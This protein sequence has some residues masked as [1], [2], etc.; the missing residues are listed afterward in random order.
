[1]HNRNNTNQGKKDPSPTNSN[2]Q[3]D[4]MN[5][6]DLTTDNLLDMSNAS[7]AFIGLQRKVGIISGISLIVGTMIGS[8]IFASPRYVMVFSGSVGM[9]LIVW[10]LCGVLAMAG[11]FCYA[12]L[13]TMIPLS[14]AEYIYLY[15]GLG[16][17]PAFLYAWTSTI[18]LKPS[19]VA[20]ICLAFG[21]YV[22]EP[23]FPGC[24]EREDLI[25]V[26]KLM[27]A[28]AIVVLTIIGNQMS[29]TGLLAA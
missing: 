6:S 23:F 19:Q 24:S 11:A 20:I 4:F 2:E 28:L 10:S 22:I 13:G 14:G 8:G 21:A 9:T 29:S 18:I 26:V 5:R 7:T 27:A 16:E 25:P 3:V 12:E 15:R 17:L 1:M